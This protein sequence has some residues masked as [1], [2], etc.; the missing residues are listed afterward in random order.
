VSC[1][2]FSSQSG[3]A[4]D[5]SL[6]EYD[7]VSLTEY[8]PDLLKGIPEILHLQIKTSIPPKRLKPY[9]QTD[10]LIAQKI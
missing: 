4:T 6:L 2:I 5:S 1:E 8:A 3:V 7:A 9:V 10:S